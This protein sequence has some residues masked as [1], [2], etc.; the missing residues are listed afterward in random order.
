MGRIYV[1]ALFLSLHAY[2]VDG[3]TSSEPQIFAVQ[4]SLGPFE[5]TAEFEVKWSNIEPTEDPHSDW[6]SL[7]WVPFQATY[8]SFV[9]VSGVAGSGST[10]FSLINGRHP[11]YFRYYRNDSMLAQSKQIAP[12]GSY[13]MQLRVSAVDDRYDAMRVSWTSNRSLGV[14]TVVEF[15]LDS[16]ALDRTA[17]ANHT[18]LTHAEMN[19]LVSPSSPIPIQTAAFENIGS[20]NLRCGYK[21]YDDST[22]C[23]LFVDP[24]LFHSAIVAGLAPNTRYYYRVGERGGLM[25]PVYYFDSLIPPSQY[26]GRTFSV[27][28]VADGGVGG[29]GDQDFQGGLAG[30]AT[31]NDP[32]ANGA[33]RVWKAMLADQETKKDDLLLFNGDL[34]YARGWPWTWEVFFHQVSPL[35]RHIPARYTYGNHEFDYGLN[36]FPLARGGDSGGEAGLVTARRFNVGDPSSALLEPV[37]L[38]YDGPL[39][40]VS[41]N[42]ESDPEE[43]ARFLEV[44]LPTINRTV[45]PWLI[46]QL[47]RPMYAS[48]TMYGISLQLRQLLSAMFHTYGVDLVLQG[49]QHYYERLCAINAA[50]SCAL[51]GDKAPVYI[52]DGSAGAEFGP[53]YTPFSPLTVYKDFDVWGYSR[54]V[55]NSSHLVWTHMETANPGLPVDT[56]TLVK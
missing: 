7:W 23:T 55:V 4:T 32:P 36:P 18:T 43:Q 39:C 37:T 16:S 26:D 17:V 6:V 1:L 8:V 3:E 56:V 9:N 45:S 10:K 34:S 15:G 52:V 38:L 46:V 22:F 35:L 20:R 42:S 30:G 40:V 53:T 24:G 50:G 25:S 19:K 33:D 5:T 29:N 44:V 28:Y 31:N 54:M 48:A 13:P 11:F 12:S 27:L 41:L 51:E 2:F 14:N 21:C 49:H 47:H